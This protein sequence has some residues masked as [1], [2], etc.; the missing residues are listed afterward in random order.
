MVLFLSVEIMP[1]CGVAGCKSGGKNQE[2]KNKIFKFYFLP[3]SESM[4]KLWLQKMNRDFTNSMEILIVEFPAR[5]YK[6][7]KIFV[8]LV[9]KEL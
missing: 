6:I 8:K 2:E 3:K 5:G 9:S 7:I 1:Y 4:R